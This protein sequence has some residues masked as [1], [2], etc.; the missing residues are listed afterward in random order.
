MRLQFKSNWAD[1]VRTALR[2]NGPP[3]RSRPVSIA[4]LPAT[5]AWD[6]AFARVESYLRAHH[7]ESRVL[8]AKYTTDILAAARALAVQHPNEAPVTLA[9]RVAHARIGEWLVHGLGE[10]DWADERFRA[11]GRLA[12]LMSEI[13]ERCPERFLSAEDLPAET[14]NR[15]STAQLL[16]GPELR[17][18]SMPPAPLEFPL[19]EVVEEKWSTFNRSAFFRASM[20]WVVLAGAAGLAWLVTR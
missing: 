7:I 4:E 1:R 13:P 17:L 5:A 19:G 12:L 3:F 10:G 14:R 9:I 8:L 20:S 18:A 11:R 15:L 6:D 2:R 16:P